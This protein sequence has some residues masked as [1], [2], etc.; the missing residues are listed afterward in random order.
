MEGKIT[1][2][3]FY[4]GILFALAAIISTTLV[5]QK[6]T[7]KDMLDALKIECENFVENSENIT[8][9]SF[10][11]YSDFA[12]AEIVKKGEFGSKGEIVDVR[13]NEKY[14]KLLE[15]QGYARGIIKKDGQAD[16]CFFV[17]PVSD[18]YFCVYAEK[19]SISQ[20]V[21]NAFPFFIM[22]FIAA[23]VASA[24]FSVVLAGRFMKPVKK[25]SDDDF[26]FRIS[27]DHSE[28]Y[29]E[30]IPILT[31]K[32]NAEK[33]K[34]QFTANV[35]HELKTPLTSILGYSQLIESEIATGN[36]VI[37]FASVISKESQRMLYLVGD[38]LKLSELEEE[39]GNIVKE[40]IDLYEVS[41]SAVE[42]LEMVAKKTGIK[43]KLSGE[44]TVIKGNRSL[45]YEL[46][47]NLCDNAIRYNKPCGSVEV[48]TKNKAV[49]VSDTGIGIDKK[50]HSRIFERFYRV[51]KSRSKQTGGTGL[52]LSI[53]KHIA[54]LHD[55]KITITSE[56]DRG[57]QIKVS[58]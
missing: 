57:T 37:K 44:P 2:Y 54:E 41:K 4:T 13:K 17:I 31:V 7:E 16:L 53:V 50:Y 35:S 22:I 43:L 12:R 27:D 49:I 8:V 56:P 11:E 51:D 58:F 29:E 23:I 26:V 28:I 1:T 38:I 55:G 25:I 5:L 19:P 14:K 18:I 30:L 20:T 39:R 15:K 42:A 6:S 3:L 48:S 32:S 36:D 52:G 40:S 10:T 33:M 24:V 34:R 46:I 9:E 21:D 47:Y 45:I